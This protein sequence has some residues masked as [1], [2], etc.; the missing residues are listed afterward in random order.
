MVLEGDIDN[1]QTITVEEVSSVASCASASIALDA[2]VCV[3]DQAR[4][5]DV[6]L[7]HVEVGKS[8]SD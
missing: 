5:A 7:D 6:T 2:V 1:G 8:M 4:G 3:A